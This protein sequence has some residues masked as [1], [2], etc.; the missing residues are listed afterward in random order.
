L[1][2]GAG[3]DPARE[4]SFVQNGYVVSSFQKCSPDKSVIFDEKNRG[5]RDRLVV[6]QMTEAERSVPVGGFLH[7]DS[8]FLE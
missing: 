6:R 4:A 1:P 8:G 5:P 3:V 2:D 7:H